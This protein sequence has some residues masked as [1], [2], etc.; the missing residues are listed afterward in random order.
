MKSCSFVSMIKKMGYTSEIDVWSLDGKDKL[1]GGLKAVKIASGYP[2]LTSLG[3]IR[4]ADNNA[5]SAFQSVCSALRNAGWP[6]PS[7]PLEPARDGPKVTVMVLPVGKSTGMLEDVF[8]ESVADDPAMQCVNQYFQCLADRLNRLGKNTAKANVRCFLVSREV[9]EESRFE[10][11]QGNLEAWIPTMP[12]APSAQKVHAFLASKYKPSL[13][14][15]QS[16]SARRGGEEYWP[17][18]HAAFDPINEFLRNL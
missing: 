17:F 6:V 4:D 12:A 7:K 5:D 15:G 8:L 10:F 14:L 2:L 11:L 1:R 13:D 3:V 9:L 18:E 16:V